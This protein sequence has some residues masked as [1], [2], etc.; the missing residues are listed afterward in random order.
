MSTM[1][2]GYETCGCI[3]E[4]L[5][6]TDDMEANV[7]FVSECVKQGLYVKVEERA[8]IGAERCPGHSGREA[9]SPM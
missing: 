3:A 2:V 4:A 6:D 1:L 8:R 9:W 5:L 7:R